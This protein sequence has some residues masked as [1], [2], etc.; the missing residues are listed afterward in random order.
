MAG[1][2]GIAD[3]CETRLKK[4]KRWLKRYEKAP[5]YGRG[6]LAEF[7][8]FVRPEIVALKLPSTLLARRKSGS[9]RGLLATTMHGWVAVGIAGALR[10]REDALPKAAGASRHDLS[11]SNQQ[12][13]RDPWRRYARLCTCFS[14]ESRTAP[15]AE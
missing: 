13:I 8:G 4:P 12:L 15:V 14:S 3:E 7:G 9:S 1:R 11:P 5:R 10:G 6:V 2:N